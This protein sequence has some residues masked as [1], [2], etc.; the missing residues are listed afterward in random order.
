MKCR[1][2]LI[3]LFFSCASYPLVIERE[4]PIEIELERLD[5]IKEWIRED[6]GSC[7]T[8]NLPTAQDSALQVFDLKYSDWMSRMTQKQLET[9]FIKRLSFTIKK[10]DRKI[11]TEAL[12][13]QLFRTKRRT[14]K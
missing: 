2:F 10:D 13:A 3:Y 8:S 9:T 6:C 4:D 7:H 5:L 1:Y 11:I 14:P 12:G